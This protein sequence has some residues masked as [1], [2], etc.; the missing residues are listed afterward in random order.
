[1]EDT[2][3]LRPVSLHTSNLEISIPRHEK[4][5]IINKLL[6]DFLIH[7]LKWVVCALKFSFKVSKGLLHE[8][9]NSFTLFLGDTRGK[10][11]S[12]NGTANSNTA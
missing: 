6:S 1:V 4:E 7:A 2:T 9:L 8:S 12:I 3:T 5:V 11:K 10:T